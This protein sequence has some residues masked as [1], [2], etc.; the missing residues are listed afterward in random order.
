[1]WAAQ[2]EAHAARHPVAVPLCNV[3]ISVPPMW[4][5]PHTGLLALLCEDDDRWAQLCLPADE[6][7]VWIDVDPTADDVDA[8]LVD[9]EQATGQ[10]L[11][12]VTRMWHVLDKWADHLESDLISYCDGQDL[13][14]LWAANHGPSLL[15]WRRLGVLY[16]GLPG[17]SLTK[18]AQANE[19]GD[20]RLAELAKKPRDGYAPMSTTDMILAELVDAV[21]WNN[22]I[23]Q[24]VNADPKKANQIKA[25]EPYPRPGVGRRRGR[26]TSEQ[27]QR[28]LA[29]MRE[30]QGATPAG[31]WRDVDELPKT[32]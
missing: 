27:A 2:V 18:T 29:Y 9:W 14:D 21:R 30:N 6:Y 32:S 13:R 8:F 16:D 12:T 31:M 28:L 24:R 11:D 17:Q 23:L 15:T 5:W 26:A 4:Q 1:V 25:P 3:D 7:E 10:N 20:A 19:L 22:Y